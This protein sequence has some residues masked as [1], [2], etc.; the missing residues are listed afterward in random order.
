[1]TVAEMKLMTDKLNNKSVV[2]ADL[3][4]TEVKISWKLNTG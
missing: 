3:K 1:M 2:E 4:L